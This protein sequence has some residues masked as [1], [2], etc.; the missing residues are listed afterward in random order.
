MGKIKKIILFVFAFAF[1]VV[2]F[3]SVKVFA[4]KPNYESH[5][6]EIYYFTDSKPVMTWDSF[7]NFFPDSQCNFDIVYDVHYY[8]DNELFE[9]MY[10]DY[11]FYGFE[12][13]T[14]VIFDIKTKLIDGNILYE[15]FKQ[16]KEQNCYIIFI[17]G[18][19][20]A[21]Y[22]GFLNDYVDFFI[23]ANKRI[24]FEEFVSFV[25]EDII[26]RNADTGKTI[27]MLV[28][29]GFYYTYDGFGYSKFFQ[30]IL[31]EFNEKFNLGCDPN[32]YASIIEELFRNELVYFL[33]KDF[34]ITYILFG[35]S[36]TEIGTPENL[37][38]FL[39]DNFC[40]DLSDFDIY[41]I[42]IYRFTYEFYELLYNLF[43]LAGEFPIY[44]WQLDD[45]SNSGLPIITD[46]YLAQQNGYEVIEYDPALDELIFALSELFYMY[47]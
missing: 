14:I 19:D 15:I 16:I 36:Q 7:H 20:E 39:N 44:A 24:S 8:I 23:K 38:E 9:E 25:V 40:K 26:F 46:S 4:L 41:A 45:L 33:F 12:E 30:L 35:Y 32:D 5:S 31:T 1:S 11:Y 18:Y 42:G 13:G 37:E 17:S 27:L 47:R 3:C 28:D 34:D 6:D 10:N 43:V 21:L 29:Y 22:G 2:T